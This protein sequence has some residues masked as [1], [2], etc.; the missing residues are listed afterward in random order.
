MPLHHAIRIIWIVLLLLPP[1]RAAVGA[2]IGGQA[3][4]DFDLVSLQGEIKAEDVA[5]FRGAADASGGKT[6]VVLNSGG[7]A[8]FA[9]IEMGKLIHLKHFATLVP[10]DTLC[11]SSCALMWLAGNP[12]LIAPGGAVGF[13]AV[14]MPQGDGKLMTS[15]SGNALVGAYLN[16]LGFSGDVI[17]YVTHAPPEKMG[18]LS[19][20]IARVIG[21]DVVWVG[22][23]TGASDT[24]S[25]QPPP[26]T[27]VSP[28][29]YD[30][31]SAVT[32]FYRAL[33][34]A[35]GDTA[36]ALVVPEKRG[37]GPFNEL[38]MTR[39]FGN[40]REPL[41][42]RSVRPSGSD[43]VVAEYRYVYANG[44][45]CN[46]RAEV[47]TAYAFGDTFIQGIKANC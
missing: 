21:L 3:G 9:G 18:W 28:K 19:E 37:I 14:Y 4:S 6:V 36:A 8:A 46:G 33:G 39:F 1:I 5:T 22:V 25:P 45:V 31:A 34:A 11:A 43:S 35:D 13:H 10:E 16:Q 7:G 40:M 29:P 41:Q 38:N 32:R 27:G 24:F 44:R 20:G 12:R 15:G 23:G 42:L 17:A 30:P 2:Q 26:R 47:T